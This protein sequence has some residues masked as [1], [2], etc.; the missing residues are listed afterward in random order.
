MLVGFG[1]GYVYNSSKL[2]PGNKTAHKQL[3]RYIYYIYVYT[4]MCIRSYF[5][6]LSV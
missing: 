4:L 6:G 2:G 1:C 5:M 3:S